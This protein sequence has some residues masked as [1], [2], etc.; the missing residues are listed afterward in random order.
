MKKIFKFF[1]LTFILLLG[2][3]IILNPK[4]SSNGAI[5]GIL[6]CG[7]VIIP[8]LFPFTVCVVFLMNSG[9]S[10]IFK[11]LNKFFNIVFGI[12]YQVFLTFVLSFLGGYPIGAKLLNKNV[13]DEKIESKNATI[14]LNYCVNAGPGFIILAV[15]TGV[16]GSKTLGIVLLFSNIFS[17][18]LIALFLRKN[19]KYERLSFSNESTLNFAENFVN[20]TAESAKSIL[21]ICSYVI[22]FSTVTA[23]LENS[24]S[25]LKS[26]VLILEVTNAMFLT[27]NI[28][29]ISFLLGFGGVSIWFQ[30][31]SIINKFEIH[32]LKFI[33]FRIVHG[34]LSS[35]STY[36][37]IKV[38]KIY[39]PTFSNNINYSY[40]PYSL[41]LSFAVSLIILGLIFIISL[42]SKKKSG[43]ILEDL[44]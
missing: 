40:S 7:N 41:R 36:L 15:G 37:I 26:I 33:L 10:K 30:I 44:V 38:F 31:F 43:N 6:L 13:E 19:L 21:G 34:I 42:N 9:V 35:I 18:L 14:I 29:L 27:K 25:I 2:C 12:N 4:V 8:T 23:I 16:L 28:Y 11:P 24:S 20:S 3:S 39:I 5:K 17:S 32:Y 1:G 22:L